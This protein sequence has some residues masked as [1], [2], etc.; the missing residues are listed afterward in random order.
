MIE[1]YTLILY[2]GNNY[3]PCNECPLSEQCDNLTLKIKND[4]FYKEE[5][6]RFF[7][8]CK[9]RLLDY[10]PLIPVLKNGK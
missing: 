4:E 1:D 8:N 6:L 10:K 2:K 5:E 7:Y 3:L 9:V